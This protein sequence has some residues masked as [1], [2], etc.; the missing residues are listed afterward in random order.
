MNHLFSSPAGIYIDE[1]WSWESVQH[2]DAAILNAKS[3]AGI[4]EFILDNEFR[5][6]T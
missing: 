4:C 3:L 6:S 2:G 5:S 1:V